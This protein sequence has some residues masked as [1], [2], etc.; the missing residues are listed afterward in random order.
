MGPT[1]SLTGWGRS[2]A[3]DEARRCYLTTTTSRLGEPWTPLPPPKKGSELFHVQQMD[4][5]CSA[6]KPPTS[7]CWV[8]NGG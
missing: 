6:R 5:R 7:L 1:Q 4:P 3:K 2:W 8:K